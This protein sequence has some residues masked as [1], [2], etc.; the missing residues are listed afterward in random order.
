MKYPVLDD[1]AS[2][3]QLLDD[4]GLMH[5]GHSAEF[6]AITDLAAQLLGCPIA[7]ISIVGEDEQW[8]KA[9]VGLDATRAPRQDAFCGHTIMGKEPMIVR[10]ARHDER[11][12]ANPLVIGEPHVVFYAGVPISIDGE[13]N[14]GTLCVIDK[15]PHQISDEQLEQLRGLA[16]VAEGLI[17]SVK[18]QNEMNRLR[19]KESRKSEE[20]SK[21]A[22]LLEQVKELTGIGGWEL[23]L[24]PPSLRW[25]D[26]T[27]RI[28]ELPLD[29]EPNLDEALQFY[30]PE[31]RAAI[32][33]SIEKAMS[34]G[35]GWDLELPLTT[36]LGNDI[37]VRA[38]GRP[39]FENGINTGLIGAFQDITER[40]K[41]AQT[42]QDSETKAKKAQ[43]RLWGAIEALP[44]AF[45]MYDAEDRLVTCNK[46]Y[47]EVYAASAPAIFEGAA[48]ED[49]IQ[50]GLD[51][52][53]YPEAV[54][55]EE[56]WL[57]ERL[58]RHKN[59]SG[60]MEQSVVGDRFLQIHEV[61]TE[62]GDTVG[63]RTDVT[64]LHRQKR[65]LERQASEME[66]QALALIKAMQDAEAASLTDGLTGL[67][68]R[69]GLDMLLEDWE[70]RVAPGFEVVLIHV[71]LD[72]FKAINDVFGHAAGDHV[73]CVVSQILRDS[74]RSN[75]YIARVG[76]D[77]FV[78]AATFKNAQSA[79]EIIA[80]RIIKACQESVD[81]NGQELRF[82]AS[83]G[84][85]LAKNIGIGDLMENA[86]IA[87]YDA[88]SSGRNRCTLFTPELRAVA[89]EKKCMADELLRAFADDQIFPHFQ[90]Q[91][92]AEDQSLVGVEALARW[93]HPTMGLVPPDVFLPVAEELGRLGDIDDIILRTSLE[94]V[95]RL[96]LQ[97]IQIPKLSVNLSYRR[98]KAKSL[99][100]QVEDLRPWPCRLAFELLE[101]IDYDQDADSFS[102]IL[103][104]LRDQDIEIELDDFGSGR[105]SITTL[106]RL[107]PDR[108]KID[109]QL[110]SSI[111]HEDSSA[112]PLVKAICEMGNSLNI[113]MTAEGVETEAQAKVLKHLG[114]S[115]FQG[116]LFAPALSEQDLSQWLKNYKPRAAW[117]PA[118]LHKSDEG[119]AT[120]FRRRI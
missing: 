2:R 88:K 12:A 95:Q 13:H 15:K 93:Q 30:G 31:A 70:Q 94:T 113:E 40:R 69:R 79:A 72:R 42:L 22:I 39:I 53:Q 6:D 114:C 71:D 10:D 90:P 41:I 107:R 49:I 11:F 8:F 60:P 34:D 59:P 56:A 77:E 110:V 116:Y 81:F 51:N 57:Q 65:A 61:R 83:I 55:Q 103:D 62:Q 46:K 27:K 89:E 19:L 63:F 33:S 21:T 7:L 47:K 14:L 87:L 3:L 112:N 106:L 36:A 84:I 76:G 108:I 86:D 82:G 119:Q 5:S 52:G 24:D 37:W 20:L 44:E 102:W 104:K 105:A 101:T 50:F 78:I 1:E 43:Q 117:T 26:E 35:L 54:G 23:K 73:L 25:T 96:K 100:N 48:F 28:H 75:E 111:A 16:K 17:A 99:L 109:R 118:L 67:G 4:I 115:V 97:G 120:P 29:Y 45:V 32:E 66:R 98:L 9:S 80:D 68:N 18:T 91:V 85:A 74:V 92:S 64:E 58:E 38:A